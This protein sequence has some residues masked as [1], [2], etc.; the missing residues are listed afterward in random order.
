MKS[1]YACR[2]FRNAALTPAFFYI[3]MVCAKTKFTYVNVG[4]QDWLHKAPKIARPQGSS[5][6]FIEVETRSFRMM[7]IPE[8]LVHANDG[9][10]FIVRT[11]HVRS[12]ASGEVYAC[13]VRPV[14]PQSPGEEESTEV[15]LNKPLVPTTVVLAPPLSEAIAE[16]VKVLIDSGKLFRDQG[17]AR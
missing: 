15:M 14:E 4:A 9:R 2:A 13:T 17:A 6:A 5:P 10:R 11:Q 16:M 8:E 7:I 1:L 12:E 3:S